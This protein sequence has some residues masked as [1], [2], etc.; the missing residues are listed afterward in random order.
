MF[1]VT[2]RHAIRLIYPLPE[3]GRGYGQVTGSDQPPAQQINFLSLV[4]IFIWSD[5]SSA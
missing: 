5:E 3:E 1:H 4:R 2:V